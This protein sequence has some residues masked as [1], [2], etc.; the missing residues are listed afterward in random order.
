MHLR[1]N[2]TVNVEKEDLINKIKENKEKHVKEFNEACVAYKKE[3]LEQLA[4]L[5]AKIENDEL[6]INLMLVTPVNRSSEYDKIIEM[7]NWD[8]KSVVELTQSE[9]NDYVHDDNESARGASMSNSMYLG[10]FK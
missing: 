2:R 10:K 1:H 6:G 8:V 3:A 5:K 9:F 4:K 7:F